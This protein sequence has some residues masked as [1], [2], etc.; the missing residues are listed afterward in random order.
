MAR[1]S[2]SKEGRAKIAKAAYQRRANATTEIDFAKAHTEVLD[3][4]WLQRKEGDK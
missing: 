4:E 3:I 2:E 1:D